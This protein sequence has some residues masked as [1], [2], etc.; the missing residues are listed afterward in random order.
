MIKL[1]EHIEGLVS[2]KLSL[3]Q[4]LFSLFKL[5]AKLAGMTVYPLLLNLCLLFIVL[6]TAWLSG[7]VL[8]GYVS[9]FFLGTTILG[10]SFVLLLN[11][12]IF[13]LL[14]VYF[15]YNLNNMSFEKT[16]ACLSTTESDEHDELKKEVNC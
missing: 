1:I 6:I 12:C 16:R 2:S 15:R 4:T 8:I 11:L 10:I 7:M 13:W 9:V 3:L 14:L 5:E